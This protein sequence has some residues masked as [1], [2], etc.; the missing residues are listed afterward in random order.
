VTKKVLG[1]PPTISS[2][3]RVYFPN[4]GKIFP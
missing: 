3:F 1:M 4:E 2:F